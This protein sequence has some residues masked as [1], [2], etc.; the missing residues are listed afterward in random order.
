MPGIDD[1][2]LGRA[3]TA[4]GGG[5][6]ITRPLFARKIHHESAGLKSKGSGP[7][8]SFWPPR[9]PIK[10]HAEV[11]KPLAFQEH[12]ILC[13]NQPSPTMLSEC[14][15][16]PSQKERG[17]VPC[18][19]LSPT[20]RHVETA[21]TGMKYQVS[22]RQQAFAKSFH[23]TSLLINMGTALVCRS[24]WPACPQFAAIPVLPVFG[25]GSLSLAL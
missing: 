22:H 1:I 20:W 6:W 9:F 5:R 21:C 3:R 15:T 10:R 14:V 4:D 24:T 12:C 13:C 16:S 2:A 19:L 17:A 11:P 23:F 25:Q 7:T 18:R 8:H